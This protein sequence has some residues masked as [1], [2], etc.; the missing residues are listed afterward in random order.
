MNGAASGHRQARAKTQ[1]SVE[2]ASGQ[3]VVV[4]QACAVHWIL[5]VA[6]ERA[7]TRPQAGAADKARRAAADR[8]IAKAAR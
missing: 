2:Q 7:T 5:R 8:L 1:R 6:Q 3:F 4:A